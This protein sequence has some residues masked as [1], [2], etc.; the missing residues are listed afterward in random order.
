MQVITR[1]CE[2]FHALLFRFVLAILLDQ[3]VLVGV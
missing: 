3:G 1:Y 2:E